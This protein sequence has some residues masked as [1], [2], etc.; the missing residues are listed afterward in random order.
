MN[1]S[2]KLFDC[3]TMYC[4]HYYHHHPPPHNAITSDAVRT[5]YSCLNIQHNYPSLI[6]Q[7]ATYTRTHIRPSSLAY[8]LKLFVSLTKCIAFL[9]QVVGL[10]FVMPYYVLHYTHLRPLFQENLG[11]PVSEKYKQSGFK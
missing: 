3:Q 4:T 11:K 2:A 8:F 9:L 6:S 1:Y 10:H 5:P 7:H